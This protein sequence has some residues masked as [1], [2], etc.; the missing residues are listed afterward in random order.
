M[1]PPCSLFFLLVL[2]LSLCPAGFSPARAAAVT[3]FKI[4]T[5]APVGSV[6]MEQFDTFTAEVTRETGGTVTF[7]AYPGGVMGDDQAMYRKMRVGQLHGGGFTMSG[8]APVVPD[9]R[10]LAIPFL[11]NSYAEVDH[12]TAALFPT[13]V[14]RFREKGLELVALTEVGFLYAMSTRPVATIDDLRRSSNW[15]PSGE[16]LSEAFMGNLGIT[17]I[18]LT[19]PDVLPALQSGLVETVYNSLYGSIVLQWF[20]QARYVIDIPYGY[21]YGAFVLDGKKFAN[22]PEAEQQA[23]RTAADHHFP[24]LLRA[25]RRSNDESRSVLAGQGTQF[26]SLDSATHRV[27]LEKRDQTIDQLVPAAI[28]REIY[29]ET[30]RLLEDYRRNQPVGDGTAPAGK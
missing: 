16:P 25:T 18:Q 30:K 28:S 1:Q 15:S 24:V 29:G 11:L 23:I 2:L 14:E 9:F 5:L 27:L 12:L 17:P 4:A 21:A 13:L 26:L 7:R 22:L 8:I 19:I 20:T 3:T 6:W 10:V